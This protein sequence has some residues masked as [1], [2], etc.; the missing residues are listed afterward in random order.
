MNNMMVDAWSVAVGRSLFA[1]ASART[2]VTN[3][4]PISLTDVSRVD[5]HRTTLEPSVRATTIGGVPVREILTKLHDS[6]Q[7]ALTMLYDEF[8]TSLWRLA[9]LRTRSA[10]TAEEAVHDVFLSLWIR[11]ATINIDTDIQVYLAAA[12]RNR[13]RDVQAHERVV[14]S[15]ETSVNELRLPLPAMSQAL[16]P[17]DAAAEADEFWV[18]YHRALQTLTEREREAV[19]LRWEEGLTLEQVGRIL[20]MSTMGAQ[21]LI[22]RAQRK[23][24]TGLQD[25][26]A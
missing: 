8:F 2:D 5:S 26:R 14:H 4:N 3:G 24:R 23:V 19:L 9:M 1:S 25:Y 7:D 22:L 12:V 20:G 15:M 18:A 6:D 13:T 11:R 10:E 17:T 21:K 16:P